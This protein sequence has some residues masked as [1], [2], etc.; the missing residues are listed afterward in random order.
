[1]SNLYPKKESIKDVDEK[2]INTTIEERLKSIKITKHDVSTSS[3]RELGDKRPSKER[4]M[5]RWM[6]LSPEQRKVDVD[7]EKYGYSSPEKIR[8]GYLSLRQF[9]EM[10]NEIKMSSTP[11][12]VLEKRA[13]ESKIS[14]DDL[15]VLLEYYKPL[16]RKSKGKGAQDADQTEVK[17]DQVFTNVKLE[18]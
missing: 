8:S 18:K 4:E 5:A 2:P 7:F 14:K 6:G 15:I 17:I 10:L 13:Q 11:V 1:L 3:P 9:D 12:S 16:Y